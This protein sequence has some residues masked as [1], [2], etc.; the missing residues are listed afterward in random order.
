[1]NVLVGNHEVDFLWRQQRLIA[2]TDG[3]RYH[4]GSAAFE[5]DHDRDLDLRGNGFDLHR[6]TYRQVTTEPS[7]VAAS[8][9]R[10]LARSPSDSS[11]AG[12]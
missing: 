5:D 11:F 10:A 4:R 7:R 1:M 8:I 2:E 12:S 6:F 3:Y 9:A